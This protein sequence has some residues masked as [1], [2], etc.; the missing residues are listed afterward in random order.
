MDIYVTYGQREGPT[1]IAAFDAALFDAGIANFNLIYLSSIIPPRS[2]VIVK[3]LGWDNKGYGDRLYVV[4]SR[5]DIDKT[6][7]TAFVGLGWFYDKNKGG[8]FVE[9]SSY[10]KKRLIS[11]LKTTLKFMAKSRLIKAVSFF[12]VIG[13]KCKKAPACALIVAVYKSEKWQRH[14]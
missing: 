8:V 1:K 12:K 2:R 6:G 14:L 3:R 7:K 5:V 13:V 11:Y 4:I 9:H 10:N